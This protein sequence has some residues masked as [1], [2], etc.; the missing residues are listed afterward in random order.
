MFRMTELVTEV[1]REEGLWRVAR[2]DPFALREPSPPLL[3]SLEHPDSG[4]GNRFDSALGD[5]RVWYF[6]TLLE[7]CYGE[8]L[9]P[10][11]PDPAVRSAIDDGDDDCLMPLGEIAADWR[12]RRIAVRATF[13]EN[14]PFLDVEAA[15]TRER[16]RD[17]LPWL[18]SKLG[19][20]EIDVGAIRSKDRRL[21]R[22]IAQWA[23]QMRNTVGPPNFGGIRF[24]SRLN[25]DW[26][27]WAVFEDVL[28]EEKE[29]KSVLRQDEALRNVA[30]LYGL[31]IF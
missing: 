3:A 17:D 15:G 14:R 10:L 22:W 30:D 27:C 7:G 6:A 1:P 26:E 16:L 23:W 21:T 29:R 9:A 24:L 8:T 28:P 20:D 4:I 13:P 19:L 25:T 12:Q 11:R 5:F 2:G 18:L 31:E